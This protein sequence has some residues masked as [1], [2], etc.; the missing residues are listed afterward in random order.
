[1]TQSKLTDMLVNQERLVS[2]LE[3]VTGS[4][5]DSDKR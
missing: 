4:L 5:E 3:L 2:K 1:M